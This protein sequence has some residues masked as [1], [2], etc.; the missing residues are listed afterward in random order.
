MKLEYRQ[1]VVIWE[2]QEE[3]VHVYSW[4]IES[5]GKDLRKKKTLKVVVS[6]KN[7]LRNVAPELGLYGQND[8]Q[9]YRGF[10]C[11]PRKA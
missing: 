9:E 4:R 1:E 7:F 3:K 8:L 10:W 5:I 2:L 6:V 11:F